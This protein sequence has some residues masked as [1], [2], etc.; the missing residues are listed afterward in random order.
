MAIGT[1]ETIVLETVPTEQKSDS[2]L[3]KNFINHQSTVVLYR[4]LAV[5]NDHPVEKFKRKTNLYV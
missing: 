1:T 5:F 3:S 4:K 2:V